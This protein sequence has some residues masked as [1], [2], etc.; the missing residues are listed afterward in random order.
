MIDTHAHL[1]DEKYDNVEDIIANSKNAGVT[2]IICASSSVDA[3]RRAVAIANSHD[4]IFATV[5]V[6]PEEAGDFC[7]NIKKELKELAKG[8]KV[9][10]IGEIGLDYHY[11]FCS[12]EQQKYAFIEQLKLA[13][14]LAL[15]VV[16]HSRDAT[17]DTLEI[18]ES[19]L[20][21]LNNGV[22]I[23][24]YSMGVEILKRVQKLGFY[25]SLGG[26][27]TF[28]N[29]RSL[30]DVVK[31]VDINRIMLETDSPYMSPEPFRGQVNEPKNVEYVARKIAEI[32][33]MDFAKVVE[34]TTNNAQMFFK[35]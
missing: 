19:H 12:R 32:K 5:G 30:L 17:L 28:K 26:A 7:A 18:L 33:K 22:I 3:S 29:A 6:H 35:I 4:N 10:A 1:Q 11:E 21:F 27:I 2:K 13:N 9:V 24:C 31:E 16:I 34:I 8:N 20:S 14:E 15:P 23:H 25:I